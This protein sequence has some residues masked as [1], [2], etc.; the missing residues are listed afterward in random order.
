MLGQRKN[1]SIHIATTSCCSCVSVDIVLDQALGYNILWYSYS[2]STCVGSQI[3][4]PGGVPAGSR[5]WWESGILFYVT[6]FIYKENTKFCFSEHRRNQEQK[7]AVSQLIAASLLIQWTQKLLPVFPMVTLCAHRLLLAF[8]AYVSLLLV[9]ILSI[10]V[11]LFSLSD[12]HT[13]PGHNA[14][15]GQE[16]HWVSFQADIL[17]LV[18]DVSP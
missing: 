2:V 13:L 5:N 9:S 15:C 10:C 3:S 4:V 17:G 16:F 1:S 12:A 11:F 18:L 8:L 6:F 7:E 14:Q